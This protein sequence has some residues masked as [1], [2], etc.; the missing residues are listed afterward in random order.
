MADA[1]L[2]RLGREIDA[3]ST[4]KFVPKNDL[5]LDNGARISELGT[6]S[7]K[8]DAKLSLEAEK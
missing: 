8:L 4:T 1:F 7:P 2:K 5:A 3:I 6:G